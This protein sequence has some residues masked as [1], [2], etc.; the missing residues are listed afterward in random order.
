MAKFPKLNKK[1]YVI[2]SPS[3]DLFSGGGSLGFVKKPKIWTRLANLSNHLT[4]FIENP[5]NIEYIAVSK[6]SPYSRED[7]IIELVINKL[8]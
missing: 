5:W 2:Y 6:N 4:L 8:I 3:R 1:G 7:Q